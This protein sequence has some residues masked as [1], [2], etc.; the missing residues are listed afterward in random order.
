LFD[1]W[2]QN[3]GYRVKTHL[4]CFGL[5]FLF[6]Q[7]PVNGL[8]LLNKQRQKW[9]KKTTKYFTLLLREELFGKN[10]LWKTLKDTGYE[11]RH[12]ILHTTAIYTTPGIPIQIPWCVYSSAS[13]IQTYPKRHLQMKFKFYAWRLN[14]L[15]V[16]AIP[17][18]SNNF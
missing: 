15:V 4:D 7:Q 1:Y 2:R 11:F 12:T 3:I 17:L 14:L 18:R 10:H 16:F 8:L 9:F 5:R 13:N 6:L